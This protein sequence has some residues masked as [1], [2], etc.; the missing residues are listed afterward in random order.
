MRYPNLLAAPL[1]ALLLLTGCN[2]DK[3]PGAKPAPDTTSVFVVN[4]GNF[5]RAN[6]SVSL[7]SKPDKRVTTLDLFQSANGRGLGDVVQSMTV[8]DNR[9]YLVVNNSN[10]L[11]VVSVPD[12]RAVG[13]VT[14]LHGPR[15]FLPVSATRGYVT[16]WGNFAGVRSGI[17]VVDL[18]T[19]AV[20]DSILTGNLPERLV[21]AAGRV[22]VAN[23][24]GN[25]LT[26]IDP[27][28]DRKSVV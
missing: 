19:Y 1:L 25:T 21:L 28:T 9:A 8:R 14:G 12:F 20:V 23:S 3:D 16:Q 5:N 6:G 18:A 27:A 7:Y 10:K 26:V 11:E 13:V 2:P 17:K 15:Y 4:E 24:G 22:F